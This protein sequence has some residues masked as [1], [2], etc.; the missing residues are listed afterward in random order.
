MPA[1]T[2]LFAIACYAL[3]LSVP[4]ARA[5]SVATGSSTYPAAAADAVYAT[6][7]PFRDG[8]HLAERLDSYRADEYRAALADFAFATPTLTSSAWN[9][10]VRHRALSAGAEFRG[11]GLDHYGIEIHHLPGNTHA[12]TVIPLPATLWL[13]SSGLAGLALAARARRRARHRCA[14]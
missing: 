3:L 1:Q 13:L 8:S 4:A 7:R 9:N 2:V 11:T 5:H 12:M 14:C 6:I 10:N